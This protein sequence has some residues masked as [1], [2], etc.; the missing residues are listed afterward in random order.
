MPPPIKTLPA[1]IVTTVLV[2]VVFTVFPQLDISISALFTG[3]DRAFPLADVLV[4]EI[5]R[6]AYMV[7]TVVFIVAVFALFVL[8]LILGPKRRVPL[9]IWAYP[10]A[11]FLTGPLLLVNSILKAYWGRARP[12]DI[13]EFGGD[14]QF[15]PAYVISDQCDFNCSFT[16]GEGAAIGTLAILVAV[17]FWRGMAQRGKVFVIVALVIFASIGA[18]LRVV[19]GAHFTS[20]TLLSILFCALIAAMFYRLFGMGRIAHMLTRDHLR[21][22]WRASI[23]RLFSRP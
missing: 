20:D 6:S 1:L 14:L 7:L 16:S 3:P 18:G 2:S 22:D 9:R 4:L 12:R 13:I 11:V 23:G 5:L 8:S 19:T 15:S 21:Q 10:L 17:L